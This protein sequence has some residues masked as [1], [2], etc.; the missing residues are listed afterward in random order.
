MRSSPCSSI[1]SPPVGGSNQSRVTE[2]GS[3][4]VVYSLCANSIPSLR[5][6]GK[7]HKV[8]RS[9]PS[10]FPFCSELHCLMADK[11]FASFGGGGDR[12]S[13]ST[14]Q[15]TVNLSSSTPKKRAAS[16]TV[17]ATAATQASTSGKSEDG[18]AKKARID[19]MAPAAVEP[20][21][22]RQA[23]EFETEAKTSV[24]G[25]V[26]L[27][28]GEAEGLVLSHAVSARAEVEWKHQKLGRLVVERLIPMCATTSTM[29][30]AS[31]AS[32]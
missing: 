12:K 11:L 10:L 30:L 25:S 23:D 8:S 1:G 32:D 15:S 16:P 3:D 9:G 20:G 27:G 7:S 14:S 18:S 19:A 26:G 21:Q 17:P 24:P 28:G 5:R 6:L 22:V 4:G 2:F 13:S 29:H 31:H